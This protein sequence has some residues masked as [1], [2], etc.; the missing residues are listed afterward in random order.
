MAGDG[1][2][3]FERSGSTTVHL[4]ILLI[5]KSFRHSGIEL[6]PFWLDQRIRPLSVLTRLL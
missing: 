3:S 1:I 4:S 2:N 5:H 6:S